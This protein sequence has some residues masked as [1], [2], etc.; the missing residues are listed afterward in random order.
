LVQ[1][2]MESKKFL[3]YLIFPFCNRNEAQNYL[4]EGGG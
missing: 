2:H 3:I 1:F 4:L